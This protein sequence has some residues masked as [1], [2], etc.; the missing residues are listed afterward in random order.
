M[1]KSS[2]RGTAGDNHE[3]AQKPAA[4]CTQRV[5]AF[6]LRRGCH[7][8]GRCS[9]SEPDAHGALTR[10]RRA[11][12]AGGTAVSRR[13]LQPDRPRQAVLQD[14]PRLTPPGDSPPT[15]DRRAF[16]RRSGLGVGA[17]MA[18]SQLVLVKKAE[19]GRCRQGRPR[20]RE[21][22]R[23]QA[24]RLRPLLGGLCR[25]CRG[26]ERRLGAPG[27]GVRLA[28]Q[29]RRALRQGR[30]AARARPR[31]IP[32]E[33]PDEAGRRQ[34]PAH[35]LGQALNEIS[36]QAAGD[37][38]GKRPGCDVLVGSSKHNN[39]QAYLL[40]KFV[41]F[42]GTNNWTTRPAS[43]TP[44]RWPASPTPGAMAR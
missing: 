10:G 16:L 25:R 2:Y 28:H 6:P 13:R 15:M 27:A 32:P 17:G 7:S 1:Q 44:P 35:Q 21:E 41:S 8:G 26:R 18:A 34:V 43:A 37:A 42:W 23:G 31:R 14:H 24:H 38:Q 5:T 22:G 36:D 40:R 30:G 9:S 39:E 11:D 29:P 19:A 33:V 4:P 12:P 3:P 20:R